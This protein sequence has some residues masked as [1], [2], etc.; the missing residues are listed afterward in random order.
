[1]NCKTCFDDAVNYWR[2]F[3]R[4]EMTFLFFECKYLQTIYYLTLLF[5]YIQFKMVN[6]TDSCIYE[7]ADS[8]IY[9]DV[10]STTS[11][12]VHFPP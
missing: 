5:I 11:G 10:V 2:L 7:D 8:C 4:F 6:G 12:M 1:M 9:E 3:S